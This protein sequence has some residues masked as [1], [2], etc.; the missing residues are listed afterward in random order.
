MESSATSPP[1]VKVEGW[2]ERSPLE[3][4]GTLIPHPTPTR[5]KDHRAV[6]KYA[7]TAVA[8]SAAATLTLLAGCSAGA[9]T[10]AA[11]ESSEPLIVYTN[12][13]AD[14]RAE[15]LTAQAAEAGFEIQ[16][17][18]QGGG[19]TTEKLIAEAGNP[20]AD[21]V[22]GL[23]NMYF[24]QLIAAD[25]IEP[26]TPS[27]SGEVDAALGDPS[28]EGYYWPLVQQGIVLA[29]NT[30]AYPTPEDAPQDWT[31]LWT[32]PAFQGRYESV[33]DLGGATSQLVFAGILTRYLDES[34]DLGVSDEGW[35]QVAAY[36]EHGNPAVPDTDLYARMAEGEVDM[37]QMWTSGLPSREEEYGI[38]SEVVRPE[39]GVPYAVEQVAIVKGTDQ[40]EQAQE[41]IDWFGSAE[42][43]AAWSAEFDSMPVNEGAIAEADPEIV[44]FHEN[45]PRQEIDW[46]VVAENLPAWVEKIELEYIP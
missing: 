6:H 36:F 19:D 41:F 4:E 27:W 30:A 7:R 11:A 26:Y 14:G 8:V 33:P 17:V 46:D 9:P 1:L 25:T 38:D 43:Q 44:E 3:I 18:G 12:S 35:E 15:W 24:S 20:V 5:A 16:I 22:F 31:D 21:V 23:N 2:G 37:G 29:Y 32:D 39:V 13:N 34:G 45:L 10:E 28:G 40:T 42:T